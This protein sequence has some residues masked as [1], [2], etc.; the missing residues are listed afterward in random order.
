[1]FS[2]KPLFT[3]PLDRER[4]A[5]FK[6]EQR[7]TLG[8]TGRSLTFSGITNNAPGELKMLVQSRLKNTQH[9]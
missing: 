8:A 7:F 6:L 5:G 2:T 3:V 1:M 4:E 9:S